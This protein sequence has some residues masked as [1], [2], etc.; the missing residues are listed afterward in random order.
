MVA[1][2][3]AL[4]GTFD[5]DNYG[6]HLFPRVA[7]HELRRR[8]PEAVVDAYSPYGWLHP[9]GLDGGRAASPLG[10][11]SPERARR[12]AASH[13][14]VVVGGGELI[15]LNDPLLAPVYE[16][17]ADE[18]RRMA[19]SRFFVE[20]LGPELEADCPVVW[21]GVGVPW[22]PD[23]DGA[24]RLRAALAPRPY[25]TVRDRHSAQ[26]LAEAGVDRPV[27]VVPD[28]A[29]LV[30]RILPLTSLCDRLDRL[31]R[32]GA[33]P[34]P[35]PAAAVAA[36]EPALL[37]RAWRDQGAQVRGTAAGAGSGPLVVQGCDLLLAHLDAVVA[38]MTRWQAGR[39][40]PLEVVVVETG[41]CRGDAVFAEALAQALKPGRVWRLPAGAAVEDLAAAIAGAGVFLG[42][43]LHGAITALAY[44]RP[45]VLLNLM[46]EAKLDGFGDLT[47]LDRYV[48]HT[49]AEILP[50]LDRA[51]AD[52]AP[53]GLL[54]DLQ[55]RID[56]HFDRLAELASG[57]AAARP[58]VR[59]DPGLAAD[60]VADHLGRLQDELDASRRRAGAAERELAALQATRTFR[61]LAPARGL[62]GRLR[63]T[64]P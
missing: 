39:P 37:S 30:E 15:H 52:P 10:P 12:L 43:S 32:A 53:P 3:V 55:H 8:L 36:G 20:G 56:R 2:R 24:R 16:T 40:V 17:T 31:R 13:H 61:V 14:L 29:L 35:A 4:W 50:A 45:F 6:D 57:R 58:G 48:V 19:P 18:L 28:S 62:Y 49:A 33:Y 23:G 27:D 38:A 41:R 9:T 26:R 46:G 34:G 11:W 1:A 63:R 60:A 7:A 42:S 25:V 5:V 51:L 59:P 54:A 64:F 47:G 21:H 44:G 22:A